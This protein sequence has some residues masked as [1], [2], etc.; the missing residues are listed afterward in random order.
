MTGM[1]SSTAASAARHWFV[2]L[3]DDEV[4]SDE[5]AQWQSWLAA[6]PAHAEAFE[7]VSAAWNLGGAATTD[8]L[9][10]SAAERA[11]DSYDGNVSVAQWRAPRAV[12]GTQWRAPLRLAASIAIVALV[13]AGWRMQTP[14]SIQAAD[15]LAT[16][17]A[18]HRS[19]DLADGSRLQLGALT[20]V[21][22][23]LTD[24]ERTVR[25]PRGQAF[26]TVAPD[27]QRP[28]VVHTPLGTV[29]AVGTEFDVDVGPD[30]LSVTV[31]EGTVV[32]DP[33]RG[34]W[35]A[36]ML[37]GA[38]DPVR[39]TANQRLLVDLA[40]A[41]PAYVVQSVGAAI[42]WQSRR[43]E[44]R[45]EPLRAVVADIN[46]YAEHPVV[47]RD[48]ELNRLGYTGTV[49]LGAIDQ[50]LQGLPLAFPIQLVRGEDGLV[51]LAR[52]S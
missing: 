7:K 42:P 37:H 17:R 15:L 48:A 18:E 10:P 44:Y 36:R 51:L 47:V 11:A 22:V 52:K 16:Q 9:L 46:R 35:W 43:L 1:R 12:R 28:F 6:D 4:T 14:A 49:Q 5:I 3:L 34:S 24:T 23:Q 30:L 26:F 45:N 32:L 31:T 29:T 33:R 27:K 2:R 40:G 21:Q 25:L 38:V 19:A 39:I 20:G 8:N 41:S 50:W 13:F